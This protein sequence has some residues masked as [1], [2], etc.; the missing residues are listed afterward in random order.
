MSEKT[1]KVI[2]CPKCG[3]EKETTSNT[4]T[5]CPNPA[6]KNVLCIE[7]SARIRQGTQSHHPAEAGRI[8]CVA[9]NN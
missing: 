3:T 8:V 9:W 2:K 4:S 7:R 1:V 6:C 5:G